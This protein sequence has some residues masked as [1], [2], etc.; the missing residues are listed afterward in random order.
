MP[1]SKA[2]D[3]D[4]KRMERALSNLS[5]KLVQPELGAG[6]YWGNYGGRDYKPKTIE[7]QVKRLYPDGKLP[8]CKD[9]RYRSK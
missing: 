7:E 4:R 1:L 9:G 5:H 6:S 2:R 8:N 3:R